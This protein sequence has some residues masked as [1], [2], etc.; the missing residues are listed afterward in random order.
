MKLTFE[1]HDMAVPHADPASC[2]FVDGIL[3]QVVEK[4]DMARVVGIQVTMCLKL[5]FKS[6]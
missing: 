4:S 1:L 5:D 2:I 6:K 3:E